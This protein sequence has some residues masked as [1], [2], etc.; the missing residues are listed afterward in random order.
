MDVYI[1]QADIY[2]ETCA[3]A[4]QAELEAAGRAPARRPSRDDADTDT[5]PAGPYPDGGGET[6]SPLHCAEC[7]EY[8]GASLTPD[9]V[10]YVIDA[11]AEYVSPGAQVHGGRG[12]AEVLDTWAA[13]LRAYYSLEAED[14]EVMTEYRHAR[15]VEEY[16]QALEV[17]RA[18]AEALADRARFA[19]RAL[20][21]EVELLAA[22]A[23]DVEGGEFPEI[24]PRRQAAEYV[25][26]ELEIALA[27]LEI[28][29]APFVTVEVLG[30]VAHVGDATPG[31]QV[32]IV[33]YDDAEAARDAELK[34]AARVAGALEA[35]PAT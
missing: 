21:A 31:V 18:G 30:G 16:A 15:E 25:A 7:G 14:Q 8:L 9:G 33:D 12:D 29:G 20:R 3:A 19:I 17:A 5:W 22:A 27:G 26:G 11:L 2:C 4:I 34:A 23:A 6:D 1:Y 10:Q 28:D 32:R 35:P 24:E 13:D